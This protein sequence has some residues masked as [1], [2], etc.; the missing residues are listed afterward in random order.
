M[1]H[2]SELSDKRVRSCGDVVKVG[3]QVE[4]RVLTVDAGSRRIGL[5]LKPAEAATETVTADLP[6]PKPRS[7]KKKL[8]GGLSSHWDWAGAGFDDLPS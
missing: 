5:S 2:I 1:I 7:K 6:T 3:Q 8:R 4:A